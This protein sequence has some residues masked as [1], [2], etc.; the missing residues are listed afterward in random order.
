MWNLILKRQG[1]NRGP[2][3]FRGCPPAPGGHLNKRRRQDDDSEHNDPHRRVMPRQPGTG[4]LGRDN[5]DPGLEERHPPGRSPGDHQQPHGTDRGHRGAED[6]GTH[7]RNVRGPRGPEIRLQIPLRRLQPGLDRELE[8]QRLE[9]RQ[10]G[11]GEKPRPLEGVGSTDP[12]E[13]RSPGAGSRG[14]PEITSTSSATRS[15]TRRPRSPGY[16]GKNGCPWKTV[17]NR[18]PRHL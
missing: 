11:R 16:P 6:T 3:P 4:R 1:Q 12:R 7:S 2:A 18:R 13:R 5:R 14:T 8:P 10:R 15:P 9:D 17:R